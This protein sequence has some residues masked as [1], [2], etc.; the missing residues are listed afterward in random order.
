MLLL[1]FLQC[2]TFETLKEF[3]VFH[4]GDVNHVSFPLWKL[5]GRLAAHMCTFIFTP[6]LY[7]LVKEIK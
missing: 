6:T 5:C 3:T 1:V 2:K 7:C 4:K